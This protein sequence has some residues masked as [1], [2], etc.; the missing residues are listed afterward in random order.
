[1]NGIARA[2]RDALV[3]LAREEDGVALMLTLGIFLFLFVTCCAVYAT[4]ETVRQKVELQNAA[5]AAAYSAA[6][7]QA[8]ALS[9]MATINRAMSWTYIQMTRAQ[10]DYIAWRWIRLTHKRFRED[11]HKNAKTGKWTQKRHHVFKWPPDW[12]NSIFRP[13]RGLGCL[14]GDH[15]KEGV[16][17]YI[18]SGPNVEHEV[19]INV[20]SGK[21][22]RYKVDQNDFDYYEDNILAI[23]DYLVTVGPSFDTEFSLDSAPD[24]WGDN[25]ANVIHFAQ[26]NIEVCNIMLMGVNEQLHEALTETAKDVL[27]MNLP[28]EIHGDVAYTTSGGWS[29]GPYHWDQGENTYFSGLSNREED[30]IIF[31]NMAN[32]IPE[33]ARGGGKVK[34]VD[35]FTDTG[36]AAGLDQWFIRCDPAESRIGNQRVVHRELAGLVGKG[37]ARGYKNANY[38]QGAGLFPVKAYRGNSIFKLTVDANKEDIAE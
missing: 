31:L 10:M 19:R 25:L 5:D 34:L 4:G 3:R 11:Y 8:D 36:L 14:D 22:F 23:P 2:A 13:R 9:R 35:Y 6:V 30:E 29:E 33:H 32:G 1:M 17:W 15:D 12:A 37:I 24:K 7:V 26:L 20:P 16:G 18:G 21:A 27:F 28:E 38:E